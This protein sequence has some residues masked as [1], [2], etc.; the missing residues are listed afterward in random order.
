MSGSI[1]RGWQVPVLTVVGLEE[2]DKGKIEPQAVLLAEILGQRI[3]LVDEFEHVRPDVAEARVFPKAQDPRDELIRADARLQ[4]RVQSLARDRARFA[5]V[6]VA[7]A[8]EVGAQALHD[9]VDAGRLG[10]GL[11]ELRARRAKVEHAMR[12]QE[13]RKEMRLLTTCKLD[14]SLRNSLTVPGLSHIQTLNAV[15]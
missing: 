11:D 8:E 13:S 5:V 12:L 2:L 10:D 14:P 15:R 3:V 6:L 1:S 4:D 7:D 9:R